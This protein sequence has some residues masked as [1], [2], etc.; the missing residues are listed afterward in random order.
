MEK[1]FLEKKGDLSMK[2]FGETKRY[3]FKKN[4]SIKL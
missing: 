2:V 4:V 1:P 3:L